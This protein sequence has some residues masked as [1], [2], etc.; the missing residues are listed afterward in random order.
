VFA[1]LSNYLNRTSFLGGDTR[2]R[3]YPSNFFVGRDLAVLNLEYRT[4]S[5]QLLSCQLGGAAFFDAG[6]TWSNETDR[7]MHHSTGFGLRILVPQLDRTVFRVDVG[8][9]IEPQ[10]LPAGVSSYS[11]FATFDQAFTVPYVSP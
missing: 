4:R 6:G 5:V 10:G 7:A 9:P 2:L 11:V 1:R 8:F 3:G